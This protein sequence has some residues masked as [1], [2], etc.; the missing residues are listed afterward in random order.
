[1]KSPAMWAIIVA[2]CCNNFGNYTLLTKLPAFMKEV[3]QFDIKSVSCLHIIYLI[4]FEYSLHQ[5]A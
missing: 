5:I 2:H 3:L 1:M 4:I